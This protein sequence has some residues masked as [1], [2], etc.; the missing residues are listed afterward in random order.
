VTEHRDHMRVLQEI[1]A[2]GEQ[3]PQGCLRDRCE[4]LAVELAVA[5]GHV[6]SVRNEFSG[7]RWV[8]IEAYLA[9][10]QQVELAAAL[11]AVRCDLLERADK[12]ARVGKIIADAVDDGAL[13]SAERAVW[14]ALD[15]FSWSLNDGWGWQCHSGRRVLRRTSGRRCIERERRRMT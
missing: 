12:R 5:Y 1:D 4:I 15:G 8:V 13:L 3:K 2:V 10:F 14:A 11:G 6:A 9:G 7:I